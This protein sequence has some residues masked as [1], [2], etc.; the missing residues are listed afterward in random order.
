M[1]WLINNEKDNNYD[2]LNSFKLFSREKLYI[3][4]VLAPFNVL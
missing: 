2:P 1:F 3:D 4:I